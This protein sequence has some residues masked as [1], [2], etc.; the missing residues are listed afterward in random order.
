MQSTNGAAETDPRPTAIHWQG[1]EPTSR[2][3]LLSCLP[4][5]LAPVVAFLFSWRLSKRTLELD[6]GWNF[7][8]VLAVR[9]QSNHR[10]SL[11]ISSEPEHWD[12]VLLRLLGEGWI[13]ETGVK[14][15]RAWSQAAGSGTV[16]AFIRED[17]NCCDYPTGKEE[18]WRTVL[19]LGWTVSLAPQGS[20]HLLGLEEQWW[21]PTAHCLAVH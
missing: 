2:L 6:L 11:G 12:E 14:A 1:V 16:G 7:I 9:L 4:L 19:L 17:G 15:C 18:G 21:W 10:I 3:P 20:D 5:L 13:N 8:L